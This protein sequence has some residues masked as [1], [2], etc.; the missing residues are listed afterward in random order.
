MA[1]QENDLC[2][3][4]SKATIESI[5]IRVWQKIQTN[6]EPRIMLL[7]NKEVVQ[8]LY[9]DLSFLGPIVHTNK[10]QDTKEYKILED[11]WGRAIVKLRRPDLKL[12][13]QWTTKFGEHLC[14]EIYLLLG[15]ECSKPAKKDHHQPDQEVVDLILEVKTETYYTTG[16]AGEKILGCPFKYAEVP[17]LYEKPLNILC[18]GG[19]EKACRDEYGNL[20]DKTSPQKRKFLEFFKAQQIE[21]VGATD[22]LNKIE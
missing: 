14:E 3:L 7:R 5:P 9:G 11:N 20:G 16:T 22:L 10:T 12:D 8:W 19:A 13:K 4:F 18:L 15:K 1:S 2:E 6:P 21:Y 17:V